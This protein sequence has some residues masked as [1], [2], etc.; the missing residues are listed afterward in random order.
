MWIVKN[1]ITYVWP[2][3]EEQLISR[4][5]WL[6]WQQL[7]ILDGGGKRLIVEKTSIF[8]GLEVS[9]FFSWGIL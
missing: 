1:V 8:F 2:V 5:W 6:G 4:N 3:S 7:F 9:T